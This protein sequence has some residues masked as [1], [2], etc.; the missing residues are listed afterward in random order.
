MRNADK[1]ASCTS[2]GTQLYTPWAMMKSNCPSAARSIRA[3]SPASSSTLAR[4]KARNH[5]ATVVDL[6]RRQIDA[7]DAGVR[8]RGGEGDQ[9]AP[10][11]TADFEHAGAWYVGCLQTE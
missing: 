7:D 8:M 6:R 11:G 2:A 3:I 10:G 9:I 5:Q 1:S 4:P